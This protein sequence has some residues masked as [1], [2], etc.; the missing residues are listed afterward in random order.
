MDRENERLVNE[1]GL[2]QGRWWHRAAV[3]DKALHLVSQCQ[4]LET[5]R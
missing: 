1:V 4:L 2:A 3:K 5:L